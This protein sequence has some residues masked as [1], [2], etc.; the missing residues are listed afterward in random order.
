MSGLEEEL[1]LDESEFDSVYFLT[2]TIA[3]GTRDYRIWKVTSQGLSLGWPPPTAPELDP[4]PPSTTIEAEEL[5]PELHH[6]QPPH[7]PVGEGSHYCK[8]WDPTGGT[9]S[10]R[11]NGPASH[12]DSRPRKILVDEQL[13][14]HPLP[15]F[16]RDAW[17]QRLP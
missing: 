9:G 3:L 2:F 7:F 14:K 5:E 4:P 15:P 16:Y 17:L 10:H 11:L 13:P 6:H 1:G 12:I 8:R